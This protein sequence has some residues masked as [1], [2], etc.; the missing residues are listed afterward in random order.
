LGGRHVLHT[1]IRQGGGEGVNYWEAGMFCTLRSEVA[2]SSVSGTDYI[3][4]ILREFVNYNN[5][6]RN[7]INVTKTLAL[8]HQKNLASR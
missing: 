3:F 4:F 6:A 8:K 7:S 5:N 2:E 1:Q